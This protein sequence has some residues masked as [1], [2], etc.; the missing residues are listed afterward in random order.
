MNPEKVLMRFRACRCMRGL[1]RFRACRC[2]RGLMRFRP[3]RCMR[4]LMRFRPCRYMRGLM[5]FRPC[6]YM[7]G[8]LVDNKLL[9]KV[10]LFKFLFFIVEYYMSCYERCTVCCIGVIEPPNHPGGIALIYRE[11][12]DLSENQSGSTEKPV[13]LV[14]HQ[15]ATPGN[16]K[17]PNPFSFY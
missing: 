17:L 1:M 9:C 14:S 11:N 7:R 13:K 15:G 12:K 3:C 10:L 16:R 6:R 8:I 5:R 4:G 2:M